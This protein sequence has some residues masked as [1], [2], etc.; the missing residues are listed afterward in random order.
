VPVQNA[1]DVL[2]RIPE[3][4]EAHPGCERVVVHLEDLR[5]FGVDCEGNRVP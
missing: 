4:L 3:I 1:A 2:T 5:L